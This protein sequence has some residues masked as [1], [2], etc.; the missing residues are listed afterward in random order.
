[1]RL[2]AVL[3]FALLS[4][5]GG[6]FGA[7]LSWTGGGDGVSWG[8]MNNWSPNSVP[9]W[10][11]DATVV[12]N[13]TVTADTSVYLNLRNLTVG[14]G[15]IATT[16][17]VSTGIAV[18]QTLRFRPGAALWVDGGETVAASDMVV[19]T[20]ARITHSGPVEAST[21]AVRLVVG[22]LDM[23]AGSTV[24]V[25]GRGFRGGFPSLPGQ[26]PGGAPTG[27]GGGG[28]GH[29]G[30]GG[31][32]AFATNGGPAYDSAAAPSQLGSG[33]GGGSL[34]SACSGGHGG[35]YVLILGTTVTMNGAVLADGTNGTGNCPRSGG[36]GSGGAI[37]IQAAYFY[38]QPLLTARGGDGGSNGDPG[39]GGAGGRIALR[40]T[41][42]NASLVTVSTAPGAGGFGSPYG[43][44]GS[45]GTTHVNPKVWTGAGTSDCTDPGNWYAGLAPTSG[46]SV[47]F[48][49][50]AAAKN[51]NWSFTNLWLGSL[52]LDASYTGILSWNTVMSSVTGN[53]TMA[54]GTLTIAPAVVM[55][56]GGDLSQTGGS[57]RLS[58]GTVSLSGTGT[59]TLSIS[60]GSY[61]EN[62]RVASAAAVT[63]LSDLD[64]NGVLSV[65]GNGSLLFSSGTVLS[66]SGSILQTGSV[67]AP[68]AHLTRFD[69]AAPQTAQMTR[70]GRLRVSNASGVT[71]P[72]GLTAVVSSHVVVDPGATLNAA[73][74]TL[75]LEGD[76]DNQG[77]FNAAGGT[78]AFTADAGTQTV[79]S[80]GAGFSHLSVE[81]IA[82]RVVLATSVVAADG[83]KVSTGMLDL[84]VATH[85]VRGYWWI[86]GGSVSAASAAVV[87]DGLGVQ[88]VSASS[89]VV[90]FGNL[91][92]SSAV[93]LVLQS[94]VDVSGDLELHRGVL[95]FSSRS[96]TVS[97]NFLRVG[98]GVPV[99]A[100][101][102]V[103]MNGQ[104]RQ[105]LALGTGPVPLHSLV[106]A[107]T[108]P[109]VVLGD[110]LILRGNFTVPPGSI[111]DGAAQTL[112]M[113]GRN[114][115]WNTAGAV[116]VSSGFHTVQ[117]D[118]QWPSAGTLFIAA[119]STVQARVDVYR[120]ATL[121]GDL[122]LDGPGNA[123]T[124]QSL[125]TLNA[126]GSTITLAGGADISL[127]SG[128]YGH[129]AGSWIVFRGTGSLSGLGL[130]PG[131]VG[132]LRFQ[133]ADPSEVFLLQSMSVDQSVVVETG[134]VRNNGNDTLTLRGHLINAGGTVT[135]DHLSTGTL[136]LAGTAVQR[137]SVRAGDSFGAFRLA[138]SSEVVLTGD[139]L[140]VNGGLTLS[141][142]TLK[143]GSSVISLKGDWRGSGGTFNAQSS[144]LALVNAATAQTYVD[145]STQQFNGLGC[146]GGTKTFYAPFNAGVFS[147]LSP[148]T[149]L[150][151]AAGRLFT[152]SDLRVNGR[153][154]A[155]PV[156]LRSTTAGS[157]FLL[158]VGVSTVT[159]ADVRDS[160]ARPGSSLFANDGE[161]VDR[162]NTPGWMFTPGLVLQ[163][164]GEGFLE[165]SG[166]TGAPASQVAGTTFTVTVR[167]VSNEF[168]NVRNATFSVQVG[169]DDPFASAPAPAPLTLGLATFPVVMRLAEPS[170]RVATLTP[171]AAGI[172]SA[173]AAA[174]PIAAGA[175][176]RLQILLPG[177]VSLPGST[178]GLGGG[179]LAQLAGRAF[180]ATVRA[181]DAYWNVT[182]LVT[183]PVALSTTTAPQASLPPPQALLLGA[184]VFQGI[185]LQSSGVFT[186]SSSDTLN[187]AILSVVSSTFAVFAVTD[188][189]P[190]ISFALPPYATVGT[191][192]GKL[193]GGATD[194]VGVNEVRAA[195]AEARTGL[196]LD[197]SAG[198]FTLGVPEFRRAEASPFRGLSVVWEVP[199]ADSW[200][201][202]GASYYIVVQSSNPADRVSSFRSTFT[203]GP[204]ALVPGG[205]DGLGSVSLQPAASVPGCQAVISTWVFTAGAGGIGPGGAVALRV[206]DGWTRIQGTAPLPPPPGF[207]TVISTSLAWMDLLSTELL[208]G[209]PALGEVPLGD[210]W[211]V[212][213][214]KD[215]AGNPFRP[216]E[217]VRFTYTGLPPPGP[218]SV[219]AQSFDL[220]TRA[221]GSGNLRS[222]ANMPKLTLSPGTP[223]ALRFLREESF[224]VGPLQASPTLQLQVTD[225]CGVATAAPAALP[226]A[227]SAGAF[228]PGGFRRDLSAQFLSAAGAS[229][230]T[231]TVPAGGSLSDPFFFRTSTAGVPSEFVKATATLSGL[232]AEAARFV[233][234]KASSLALTGVSIDTGT[235]IPGATSAVLAAGGA[236]GQAFIRFDLRDASVRW[237]LLIATHPAGEPAFR[238]SGAGDPARPVQVSWDGIRCQGSVCGFPPPGAYRVFI[239]AAQ[240]VVS[241][242]S[243]E[244]R[245]APTAWIR[246]DLGAAGAGALVRAEGS[247]AGKGHFT[248][249]SSTGH[250][251]LHG[252]R[253]GS[254]YNVAATT[255]TSSA[256][257][258]VTLSTGA[259]GV[260]AALSGTD[261]GPLAFPALSWI[262]VQAGLPQV[263]A[264]ELWGAVSARNAGDSRRV[265]G[266]LHY[267][268]GSVSS[269]DG[270]GA[271]GRAASSWTVLAL[272]PDSY[273]LE[274]SLPELRV[275]TVIRGVSASAGVVQD[276]VVAFERKPNVY[277]S[278]VLPSTQAAGAWVGIQAVRQ[279]ESLPS[280]FDGVFV[281]APS[282]GLAPTSA[283]YRIYGLDPGTWTIQAQG[284]GFIP[285][286]TTVYLV[287][288]S[289]LGDPATGVGLDLA[290]GAGRVIQGT[291]TVNGDSR[292]L[293]GSIGGR[294]PEA[295]AGAGFT[296]FVEAVNPA[297]AQRSGS[298]VSLSTHASVSQ[299]TFSI[300]GLEAGEWQV[301]AYLDGFRKIPAGPETVR[302]YASSGTAADLRF[303]RESARA[304]ISVLIPRPAAP[305][306]CAADFQ[307]VGL[308][309]DPPGAAPEAVADVTG[310]DGVA[311]A[312]LQY[313]QSSMTLLTRPFGDGSYGFR[314]MHGR[315]GNVGEAFLSL[316]N[317]A[318]AEALVDLSGSTFAV[319]GSVFLSGSV[320]LRRGGAEVAVSSAAGLAAHASTSSFCLLSSSLPV[321]L[322][323]AHLELAPLPRERGGVPGPFLR[324]TGT[325]C[326]A[327]RAESPGGGAASPTGYLAAIEP[328]GAYRFPGV[329]PGVYLLRNQPDLD[330]VPENGDET[331]AVSRVVRVA[332]DTRADLEI[333]AGIRVRGRV[334]LGAGA[335]AGRDVRVTLSVG[336][337]V[338]A[339][340]ALLHFN[341]ESSL[342][343]LFD[344]VP[345]GSGSIAAE[346]MGYPKAAAAVPLLV[347]AGR[348]DLE[349]PEIVLVP[350]GRIQ[351]RIAVEQIRQD[352]TREFVLVSAANRALLPPLGVSAAAVPW[353]QGSWFPAESASCGAP[354]CTTAA[355][356][357]DGKFTIS[358][359]LPGLYDVVFHPTNDAANTQR[360]SLDLVPEVRS[361]IA[362]D[363]G[364]TVDI[365]V[366]RL[367]AAMTLG[368]R[369]TDAASGAPVP[370][371]RI[372]ALS[373]VP[374]PGADTERRPAPESRTDWDGRYQLRGL[375]PGVR[376]YD[377][378]ALTREEDP[379]AAQ[380]VPY[381]GA[382]A[383]SVDLRST[384]TLDFSLLPAG[385]AIAGQAVA[386]DGGALTSGGDREPQ[387]GAVLLLQKQGVISRLT[388]AADIVLRSEADGRFRIPHLAAGVYRLTAAAQG[389]APLKRVVEISTAS[390]SLGVLSLQRGGTVSGALRAP[391]GT[392]PGQEDVKAVYAATPGLEEFLMGTLVTD[393]ETRSV[394]GYRLS[395]FRSGTG[396]RI[397]VVTGQDE[398]VSPEEGL[399]VVLQSSLEARGLDLTFRRPRPAAMGKSR[400]QGSDF[401]LE[402]RLP[403]PLRSRRVD[404]DELTAVLST[405]SAGGSLSAR[406]LSAD[407]EGLSAVYTPAVGESSFTLRLRAYTA[408]RDP[409]S[410]DTANPEFLVDSTFTFFA[411]L[412]G[413]HQASIPN[414]TGGSLVIEGGGGSL[415]LPQGAFYVDSSSA[416]PVTL[417]RSGELLSGAQGWAAQGLS[418]AE[419]RM[420]SLRFAPAAYPPQL[421]R[422]LAASPPEVTPLSAYYDV[423]LPAG[424][425]TVLAKPA[426]LALSY[427]T[428]VDPAKLNVYWYN[429]AANAYILQQ[430]AYGAAPVVDAVARTLTLRVGHFSTFVLFDAGAAAISGNSFSGGDLEAFN[431]PN[432]FDLSE[433]TVQTIHGSAGGPNHTVRGTLIRI[434]VP[435]DLAGGAVIHIFNVAGERVR[436]LDLGSLAGGR[437]YYQPWDGRND[438]GRDA[439]SGVYIGQVRVGGRSAFFKMAVIK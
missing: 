167:A 315:S 127:S 126:S 426:E 165:H 239:T 317:G 181:T 96:V 242:E 23:Q 173:V 13:G 12:A 209:P 409:S 421:L 104:Y 70:F 336:E 210:S 67:F 156:V 296:V 169:S 147:A 283:P 45:F 277:G 24:S 392:S 416:V 175:A 99:T 228:D 35:G 311:G 168:L 439:A 264:G 397:T 300:G 349:P 267:S 380:S 430:D 278:V 237:E 94:P 376:Y 303:Y 399:F 11:D 41:G 49:S 424:V 14:D 342:E 361:G 81:G 83:I 354:G 271:R 120:T 132:N 406:S 389:Y 360:G 164:P 105:F 130:A 326:A 142:G 119:G 193:T 344:R 129:D 203:F 160:D 131:P 64:V 4:G 434:S 334:R 425:R 159:A 276:L 118:A 150:Q 95:D 44:N 19:E 182:P 197:W 189:S 66:A 88:T 145:V 309:T 171:A 368:G 251:Q 113:H 390:L 341:G 403:Q 98:G 137:V 413:Y 191:L 161:S 205:G 202:S 330:G 72:S 289:D 398:I 7:A 144:T 227:L 232:P 396:Y 329:P 238:A 313:F 295:P 82:N 270:A 51:C 292:P 152:V 273:D 192:N 117:W 6:A 417:Q 407:R 331:P 351:G 68:P 16:L 123:L 46:E 306:S 91:V 325:D 400:R 172:P 30:A 207:I 78:V 364:R 365:G 200:L 299:A 401:L 138:S 247:G 332:G 75:R 18:S 87:F 374:A 141:S 381:E 108:G 214:V 236:P 199:F 350:A 52:T 20:G 225:S 346:D 222:V 265:S 149:T 211:V 56:I 121:Q 393:P 418:P 21:T 388:P 241:D 201:A 178:Q 338:P 158:S 74:A 280:V 2:A 154:S 422:A 219:G 337:S 272:P 84:G 379:G 17:R 196:Y 372:R 255:E 223:R 174:V 248:L 318:T 48:A 324:S 38:G 395:G 216:G 221:N 213:R 301:Q 34:G 327:Y 411:G 339:R 97:G 79:W 112:S 31:A 298:L 335:A 391:D 282:A 377:I 433:K 384:A 39:G 226:I 10:G 385:Y 151:F 36:G 378:A 262:R 310:L 307:D 188:S 217:D 316:A 101:S 415:T 263:P 176:Q 27:G 103:T 245:L 100:G 302:L 8:D 107:N 410:T 53:F 367:R 279:G 244:V 180:S 218:G 69:G 423:M 328:D 305:C 60:S 206:P 33:G 285:A 135:L 47:V 257:A 177:E 194:A 254:L 65:A 195:L 260:N 333:P 235:L 157:A 420:R 62:L 224:A 93:R 233:E 405:V 234:L 246:G 63:V 139:A 128:S 343:Y 275:S 308:V 319:S 321:T 50:T 357:P 37:Y 286:S 55:D 76:W 90:Q 114:T 358:G 261:T 274:L 3:L 110:N 153:S 362:A 208:Y 249:A 85:S 212:L 253:A 353:S 340:R 122:F 58:A 106:A 363:G 28:A 86:R 29:G 109:G 229:I 383:G 231:V 77:T 297:T 155:T 163:A 304:R 61:F 73:G 187:G 166:K 345:E 71:F 427:S 355:I 429:P 293:A 80:G 371:A 134:T 9:A 116:Y 387:P 438:A 243:L 111:F 268:S 26:G 125:S 146:S 136:R 281:P 190:V 375:D 102:T 402:F 408:F 40:V 220:R 184:T 162:G 356:S 432:P 198:A 25:S 359:V 133:P 428:G 115:V 204:G 284:R 179:S 140:T 437:Y 259:S 394:S 42:E 288:G 436:S 294:A 431:F 386:A 250:F 435:P 256:G 170:P 291:V 22:S 252:L 347:Q 57:F 183:D 314:L 186:I 382:A 92:S 419:A 54:G 148:A 266:D 1:M 5:P 258:A 240:G 414:L 404:D 89:T 322:S 185:V 366:V 320:R 412:D 43:A 287:S 143:A 312:A 369:V 323:A 59:Q 348:S 124:L 15:A 370:N 352:G 32:G 215:G 290:L 373:S 230:S 269:D